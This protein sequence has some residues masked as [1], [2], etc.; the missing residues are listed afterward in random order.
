[1]TSRPPVTTLPQTNDT[2]ALGDLYDF[3]PYEDYFNLTITEFY[4]GHVVCGVVPITTSL[5]PGIYILISLNQLSSNHGFYQL[6]FVERISAY[7][8]ISDVAFCII[9]LIYNIRMLA[10]VEPFPGPFCYMKGM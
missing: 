6:P 8:C 5:I 1:M 10:V 2:Q 4:I 9:R 3:D 7:L